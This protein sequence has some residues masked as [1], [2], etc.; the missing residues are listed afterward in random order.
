[1]DDQPEVC[2]LLRDFLEDKQYATTAVYAPQQ[3]LRRVEAQPE[4]FQVVILDLDFGPGQMNGLEALT[5]LKECN[6]TLPVIILSGKATV[7]DAVQALK[8]GAA[9]FLEKDPYLEDNLAISMEKMRS[10]LS[11]VEENKRLAARNVSLQRETDFYREQVQK[12]YNIVGES[13]KIRAVLEQVVKVAR[14]PRP[15]LVRGERGTGKELVAA[16]I[17]QASPRADAPFI[18][19]NCAA[20]SE[21]LLE[22]ELFGQEENAFHNAPFK[23]GRFELAN[24]GT[25]FLDEIGNMSVEFQ[26]KILRV[27]EYQQFQRVQ[28]TETITVDVRL[29]A[30][31]NTC[32]EDAMQEGRFRVDLYDRLAFETIPLPPLR[33]RK[34]DLPLLAEHFLRL[35]AA[36]VPGITVK[37]VTPDAMQLLQGYHW[38]GNVRELKNV[39]ER[40][41]YRIDGDVITPTALPADLRS[42]PRAAP[43]GEGFI[44]K[45]E[46]FERTLLLEALE[47]THWNQKEAAERLGL[48]YDQ[49]RHL[50]K[51][52][53]FGE[54]RP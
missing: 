11:I 20:L 50:Y 13:P 51:K 53:R 5:R 2:Q 18:T 46:H 47:E 21:G 25:L 19:I 16:A 15:V 23:L 22:C 39:I 31:T 48:K 28:G 45:V 43:T 36:E 44:E 42:S 27:I 49:L 29:V 35:F 1:V 24:H 4:A 54:E 26:R 17:H 40:A 8:S 10:L 3:A 38:P 33:E 12:R 7:H 34:E 9:D 6:P 52:Y 14:V 32:L 30:A 37:R 41:A